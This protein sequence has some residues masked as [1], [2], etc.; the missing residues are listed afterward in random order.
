MAADATVTLKYNAD[1]KAAQGSMNSFGSTIKKVGTMM[2]AAF[3]IKAIYEIGAAFETS[4]AKAGTLIDDT[5]VNM[6]ALRSNVL[7]LSNDTGVAA[8][9]INEGLYQA[10]SAGVDITKDGTDA[11]GFMNQM[12]KLS[13]A[14][15]TDTATAVDATTTI[16]NAYGLEQSNAAG[17]SDQ[18]IATQNEGKTTV[19]ELGGT[20][21]QV[22]PI[23]AQLG[24]QYDQVGASLATLTAN[25]DSTAE[26]STKMKALFNELGKSTTNA[27][28]VFERT[29]SKTFP[30]FIAS[31][32]TLSE[33]L[34]MMQGYADNT[35]VGISD[36]FSSI[37][38]GSAAATIASKTGLAKFDKSLNTIQT[39][40]GTT[41]AAFEEVTNTASYKMEK[42]FNKMKNAG[43]Q[44]FGALSP[45][46][47]LV[48]MAITALAAVMTALVSAI[49]FVEA[50][51]Q[52]TNTVATALVSVLTA[53]TAVWGVLLVIQNA[54][55]IQAGI[56]SAAETVYI[57]LLYAKAAAMAVVS[58]AAQVMGVSMTMAL[59]IIGLLILAVAALVSWLISFGKTDTQKQT[60]ENTE[61]LKD[62]REEVDKNVKSLDEAAAA[63]K[64]AAKSLVDLSKKFK[65]G[66]ATISQMQSQVDALNDAFGKDV[67]SI[68]KATGAILIYG[69]KVD[70]AQGTLNGLIDLQNA[71]SKASEYQGKLN[72]AMAKKQEAEIALQQQKAGTLNLTNGEINAYNDLIKEADTNISIYTEALNTAN[73]TIDEQTQKMSDLETQAAEGMTEEQKRQAVR[74]Q[75]NSDRELSTQEHYTALQDMMSSNY[76]ELGLTEEEY[77]SQMA[78]H[79]KAIEDAQA[80]HQQ[81]IED[82]KQ[83]H[84]DTLFGIN[85]DGLYNEAHTVKELNDIWSKNQTDMAN[86]YSNLNALSEAGFD[87]LATVFEAGGV[88]MGG[89]LQN[90]MDDLQGIG[91]SGWKEI[92]ADWNSNGGKLSDSIKEKYGDIN[93][94]AGI[95]VLKLSET[96]KSGFADAAKY[97]VEEVGPLVGGVE[98][99]MTNA[100][101]A[102]EKGGTTVAETSE[103]AG[104]KA[105][106]SFVSG[107]KS[108]MGDVETV[109]KLTGKNYGSGLLAGLEAMRR[110]LMSKARSL[111]I[112]MN[113]AYRNALSIHSPSKVAM[114]NTEMYGKGAEIGLEKSKKG[115][116]K[117]ATDLA[118][119]VIDAS[120][121][122]YTPPFMGAAGSASYYYNYYNDNK[123]DNRQEG[124]L[125]N[126]EEY[127]QN[128]EQDQQNLAYK[129][130]M[131]YRERALAKGA[132]I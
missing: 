124:P 62:Q 3:S 105:S 97:G 108:N 74:D 60:E 2:A 22:I 75:L 95:A 102:M 92:R 44:A 129:I 49:S 70:D 122:V 10:L 57:V 84:V 98:D 25:G 28:K 17:I 64:V 117:E 111:A 9:E 32:G 52:N 91:L 112:S 38:A 18:L 100:D 58:A 107:V 114:Y 128:S 94:K 79:Q 113:S 103:D 40:A 37:E 41:N 56:I 125:V 81:K 11:L 35:G 54:A 21:S 90:T 1:T 109:G 47:D 87:E 31:G 123:T 46:I 24:I 15:F 80:E 68:D 29:S 55:A 130:E 132:K 126:I 86:Y 23:A 42:S 66:K 104:E 50:G 14:G 120:K 93:V 71:Q 39:S 33:A 67:V 51:F 83:E 53:V 99:T 34:E 43:I 131:L 127:H 36:L 73:A 26:A 16:L 76:A 13:T 115:V 88:Q 20:L 96:T 59:G 8:D 121:L 48:S 118:N 19:A 65:S 69:K 5:A 61:A 85:E 63:N 6:T 106:D 4:F 72:D 110:S 27:A 119:T 30:E 101:A 77:I 89:D 45:V 78:E 7:K 82:S 12:L 116:E